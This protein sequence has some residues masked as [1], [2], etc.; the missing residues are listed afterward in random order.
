MFRDIMFGELEKLLF[1]LGFITLP[2][3]GTHK[4]YQYPPSEALVILPGYENQASV[5]LI[6]LVAV[7]RILMENGLIDSSVF[8]SL[9][10]KAPV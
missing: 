7:R 5:H 1:K 10:E 2:T 3:T 9:L 4:V 8:D 6:H